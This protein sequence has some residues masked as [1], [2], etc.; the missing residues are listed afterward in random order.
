[1]T[2]IWDFLNGRKTFLGLL[3]GVLYFGA[4]H[5]GLISQNSSIEYVIYTVLGVGV[6]HKTIKG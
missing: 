3:L 2:S 4:L 5:L 6:A 1:M